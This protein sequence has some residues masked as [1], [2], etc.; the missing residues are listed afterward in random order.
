MPSRAADSLRVLITRPE[1]EA[2]DLAAQLTERSISSVI[3]PLFI[4][5]T[6]Q[7]EPQDTIGGTA[8]LLTSPRGARSVPDAISHLPVYAVGQATADAAQSHGLSIAA[9]GPGEADDRFVDLVPKGANLIHLSGHHV[10]RDLAPVFERRGIT[11]QRRVIYEAEAV[12]DLPRAARAYL[13]GTHDKVVTLLSVRAAETFAKLVEKAGL[14]DETRTARAFCFGPRVA[15]C[16]Q[17]SLFYKAVDE[18]PAGDL[19]GFVD[20]VSSAST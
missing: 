16:A 4:I 9:V 5:T 8:L 18:G 14:E 6:H 15:A 2:Q 11:Y 17:A 19:T 12:T 1:P 3:A 7:L 10:A 20:F 13:T